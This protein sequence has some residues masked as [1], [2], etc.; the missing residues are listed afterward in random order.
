MIIRDGLQEENGVIRSFL[1]IGQSNM[2]GRGEFSDV[3]PINNKSCFMLRMGR[4]QKM[5]EPIN[6]DRAIFG[7]KLHSGTSLA[8]SFS[9]EIANRTGE[10]IG[11]IPCADGGTRIDLWMPGEVLYDHAVFMAKLAMRTSTLSGIIWH[12]GESDCHTDEDVLL[13]KEKFRV[14]ISSLRRELNAEGLPLIIGELSECLA[15]KWGFEDRPARMN[16]QY[17]ALAKELPNT[18]VVSS[19]GLAI[20]ADGLHFDA[21]SLRVFGKR[22]AEVYFDLIR[23]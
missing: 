1:M 22:Y 6:P 2:A 9:D 14:M 18:A 7:K 21:S 11:L 4:W 3:E 12:Q 17:R 20:K 19:E 5:S 16:V 13:H 15:E 8:A 23:I 10:R